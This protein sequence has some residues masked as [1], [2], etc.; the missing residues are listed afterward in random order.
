MTQARRALGRLGADESG[1]ALAE[2]A[3]IMPILFLLVAGII[4]FG[5]A[6]N[7]QQVVVDAS[8][9]GARVAVVQNVGITDSAT[10]ISRVHT[11]VNSRL[12]AAAIDTT[13]ATIDVIGNF[14]GNDSVHVSVSVPYSFPLLSVLMS[15]ATGTPNFNLH[16]TTTMRNEKT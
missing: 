1:Q 5:R 14:G 7:I 4:G 6:W 8:R 11:V 10:W 9:E 16:S 15:W 12:R 2:F 13:D 3:L